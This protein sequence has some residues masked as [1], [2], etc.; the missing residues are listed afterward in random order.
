MDISAGAP[1]ARYGTVIRSFHGFGQYV[2]VRWDAGP[3]SRTNAWCLRVLAMAN[4]HEDLQ[5]QVERLR[6]M[7]AHSEELASV[8]NELIK[9]QGR[10][11]HIVKK[12]RE[13]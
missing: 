7:R 3:P 5:S 4:E 2:E 13:Q 10:V 8:R 11:R 12:E 9:A 1:P 6:A